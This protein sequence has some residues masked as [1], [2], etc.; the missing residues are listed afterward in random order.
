M[1]TR[2]EGELGQV[3]EALPGG[4]WRHERQRLHHEVRLEPSGV[5][6]LLHQLHGVEA[7]ERVEVTVDAHDV[8]AC[9]W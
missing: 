8:S 3:D 1:M 4:V 9:R 2:T 6:R 5:Q 7:D